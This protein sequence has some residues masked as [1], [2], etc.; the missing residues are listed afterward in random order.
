MSSQPP[1]HLDTDDQ[2]QRQLIAERVLK[3]VRLSKLIAPDSPVLLIFTFF[4]KEWFA[5]PSS[6]T[7]GRE[8]G[9]PSTRPY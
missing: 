5:R 2:A 6:V 7:G 8:C 1:P 9:G 4:A 3:R